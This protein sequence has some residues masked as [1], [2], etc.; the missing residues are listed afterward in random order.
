MITHQFGYSRA[1]RLRGIFLYVY[2]SDMYKML[3]QEVRVPLVGLFLGLIVYIACFSIYALGPV[4]MDRYGDSPDGSY[5][6]S[7]DLVLTG[8][9]SVGFFPNRF[10]TGSGFILLVIAFEKVIGSREVAWLLLNALF[11]IG[12][13]WCFYLLAVRVLQDRI[14]A[15]FS[16][17][18]L[19]LNYAAVVFGLNY[20][21]DVSGWFFYSVALYCSF[22][23]LTTKQLMW[24]WAATAF[25]GVGGMFKEYA[26]FAYIVVAGSI[27]LVN[28]EKWLRAVGLIVVT[29]ALAGMPFILANGYTW[30]A[31]HYTYLDWWIHNQALQS[32][33]VPHSRLD[34]YIKVLGGLYNVAW[35]LF[36]GGL[37][38]FWQ[39][40]KEI[41]RDVSLQ[42]IL[43]VALSSLPILM[44]PPFQRVFFITAP[45]FALI[46]G[47]FI[48]HIKQYWLLI[49]FFMLYALSAYLMDA[50]ILKMVHIQPLLS[51]LFS[52]Y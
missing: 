8:E 16:A 51:F 31:F 13:G 9:H 19:I 10:V 37:C 39:R 17:M 48:K 44:W 24:L 32:I 1:P 28:R 23:Y 52:G 2:N 7:I 18:L 5:W 34:E 46:T 42:F 29:A 47:L 36:L 6:Q 15:F 21:A 30:L 25:V 14:A 43:L 4:P 40:R 22:R 11:Y 35:F 26:L 33:L 45:T 3:L 50:Y 12:M 38:I 41:M 49:P 20:G 27:V